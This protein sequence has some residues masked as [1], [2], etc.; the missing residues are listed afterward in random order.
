MIIL[1]AKDF[2]SHYGFQKTTMSEIAKKIHKAK[3]VLYYYFKSKEELYNAVLEH[4]FQN[5]QSQLSIV[6]NKGNDA[7]S[8]IEE[9]V[10]LRYELLS[11]ST[12]YHETLRADLTEKYLFAEQSMQSFN[13]FEK[14][15]L[16]IIL[17]RGEAE[18]TLIFKDMSATTNLVVMLLGSFDIPLFL[19]GKYNEYSATIKEFIN[20]VISALKQNIPQ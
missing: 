20:M 18:G 11:K 4:E 16:Q 17:K 12:N 14:N 5:V 19:Y 6:V 3:G 10:L 15:Q 8:T 9:Y 1:A 13:Q 2:F 7:I